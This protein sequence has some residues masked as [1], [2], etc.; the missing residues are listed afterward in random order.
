MDMYQ[1][2]CPLSIKSVDD[3]GY[4]KGYA[5][6]FNIVDHQHDV[7]LPGA[8][9][10][11]LREHGKRHNIKLLWQHHM[12]E[13]IGTLLHVREDTNGLY[14]EG[15]ISLDVQRGKEAYTLLKSRALE[16]LSIGYTPTKYYY[17]ESDGYRYLTDVDL[18]E[19]S[20]V[21][22]PANPEATVSYVKDGLPQSREEF[23]Q[24]LINAGFPLPQATS[25]SQKGFLSGEPVLNE[26]EAELCSALE[27]A[28]TALS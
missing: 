10:R 8:F 3:N 4:F 17:G 14:V 19:I 20:I 22:F 23:E 13:P 28:I 25:I 2:H 18:W 21:T 6:I 9:S 15:Q 26:Q 5:S 16:G 7:M 24:F 27:R 11:T 12:D 1:L